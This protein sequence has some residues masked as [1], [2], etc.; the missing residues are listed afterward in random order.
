MYKNQSMC[1]IFHS[2]KVNNIFH[3][4]NQ[5]LSLSLSPLNCFW[6]IQTLLF[7]ME[8]K[9][10]IYV[11]NSSSMAASSAITSFST[12]APATSSV[13]LMNQSLLLLPNMANMITVKL[14]IT[15]YT[16]WKHQITMVLETFSCLSF[17]MNPNQ[18]L[19]SFLRIFQE[20]SLL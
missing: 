1:I 18:F 8:S 3:H 13:N 5:S 4:S 9:P 12:M 15:N 10:T 16:V 6:F 17:W 19:I 11:N 14:D 20:I 7:I 2:S